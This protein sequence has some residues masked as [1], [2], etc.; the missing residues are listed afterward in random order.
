MK[1]T[2]L[3]NKAAEICL[4]SK[5]RVMAVFSTISKY[6]SNK[7]GDTISNLSKFVNHINF[8]I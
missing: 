2:L 3:K 5:M 8:D 4:Y 7:E 6:F 1:L